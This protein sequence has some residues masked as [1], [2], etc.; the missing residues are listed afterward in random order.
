MLIPIQIAAARDRIAQTLGKADASFDRWVQGGCSD[1]ADEGNA[2]WHLGN[3]YAQL[4]TL[5]E[6]L[7]LPQLVAA[8]NAD[9]IMAFKEGLSAAETNPFGEPDQKWIAP[10][11]RYLIALESTFVF[12]P[13]RAVTR[14]L[15]S[16]LRAATYSIT[17]TRVFGGLPT[18]EQAVH[19]R[20]EA[21]LRPVFSDLLHKPRLA[22]AIK[23]FEPDTGIP[24]IKT[25]IEY[26]FLSRADGAASVADELLADTLGYT[27]PDWNAFVYVIYETRRFRPEAEWRQLLRESGA[28]SRASVVVLSGEP[29]NAA[30]VNG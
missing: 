25:L 17:D 1:E 16:I 13:A 2:K 14:D 29:P 23:Q 5:A 6:A 28:D 24:S 7:Q 21:I 11:R 3:A 9:R 15:E 27:S 19:L 10:A 22:K 4:V 18:N 26:K 12:E 20:L 8:I 30:D